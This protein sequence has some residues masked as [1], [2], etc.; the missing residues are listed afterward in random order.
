MNREE[1]SELLAERCLR[2][3]L[4]RQCQE[5]IEDITGD[6]QVINPIYRLT[7]AEK[8]LAEIKRCLTLTDEMADNIT[9]FTEWILLG[10]SPE[11]FISR[12][13]DKKLS[14]AHKR[15]EYD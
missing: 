1:L 5:L 10:N 4:R 3:T 8:L 12:E 7:L 13:Y 11:G 15:G 6:N 9:D 14:D 2:D